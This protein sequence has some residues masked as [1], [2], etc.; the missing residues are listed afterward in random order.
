MKHCFYLL[1]SFLLSSLVLN[2]QQKDNS[3]EVNETTKEVIEEKD[4]KEDEDIYMVVE[5]MPEFIGGL[6][7]LMRFFINNLE[8]PPAAKDYGIK[9]R[10]IVSFTV[11]K[12]GSVTDVEVLRD[13][14]AGCGAEAKRVVETM[15]NWK[16]GKHRGKIVRVRYNLPVQFENRPKRKPKVSKTYPTIVEKMPEYPG[17][18]DAMYEFLDANLEYPAEALT[19]K[20]EGFAIVEVLIDETGKFETIEI[21][22]SPGGA[23]GE[24]AKRLVEMMPQWTPGYE[25]DEAVKVLYKIPIE[26]DPKRYKRNQKKK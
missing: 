25:K 6:D 17:G 4:T 20:V 15:P 22:E 2:A 3:G 9:G 18:R 23:C 8:Y 5:Q 7:S 14:G 12:D 26:F 10:C 16:P 1:I 21:V 24:E 19:Q 11:E 13:I